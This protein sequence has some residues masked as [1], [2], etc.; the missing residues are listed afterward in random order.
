MAETPWFSNAFG[1]FYT[2]VYAH[3]NEAEAK[4]HLPSILKLANLKNQSYNILDLG[5]GQGRYTHL[6]KRLGH[7]V[8]GLDYSLDLLHL[9]RQNDSNLSLCRG[10]ML[11]LPFKNQFDRVLSLFTSFGYFEQD[12]DNIKVI[13]QMSSSLKVGGILY[14]DFLN[15]NLVQ[16]SDW[17]EKMLGNF[18]Q[19]SKKEIFE[20]SQLV[21][22]TI[23]LYQNDSLKYQYQEKVKLYDLNWFQQTSEKHGLHLIQTFGDYEANPYLPNSSPRLI[24][25]FEKKS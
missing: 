19:K 3:R 9:A 23:E 13:Q 10:N 11:H 5:C 4:A 6:L 15:A 17:Q 2:E 24:L 8:I 7:C 12:S 1:S 14:L 20:N 22:K 25:V 21:V 16:A 18:M